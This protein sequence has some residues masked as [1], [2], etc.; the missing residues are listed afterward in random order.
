MNRSDSVASKFAKH[1]A[2]ML[3]VAMM[4]RTSVPE[5]ALLVRCDGIGDFTIWIDAATIIGNGD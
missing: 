4:F 2:L 1:S 3:I 5:S